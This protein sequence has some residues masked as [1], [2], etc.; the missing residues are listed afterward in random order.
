MSDSKGCH[1]GT[2]RRSPFVPAKAGIQGQATRLLH[3][4][5]GSPLARGRTERKLH[6]ACSIVPA[7][8]MR[9]GFRETRARQGARGSRPPSKETRGTA[10]H[11]ARQSYVARDPF[12]TARRLAARRPAIFAAPGRAFRLA[13]S[14]RLRPPVATPFGWPRAE[15]SGGL[16]GPPSASSSRRVF[17][18]AG[19]APAPPGSVACWPR[20]RAPARTPRAGATGSRP[21]RGSGE[22]EYGPRLWRNFVLEQDIW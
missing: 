8:R 12:R 21:S 10:R 13:A 11:A 6:R 22:E 4:C 1:S 19:G 20:P 5:S 7:A 16:G 2:A 15:A 18:P 9:P 3:S 17:V 14:F